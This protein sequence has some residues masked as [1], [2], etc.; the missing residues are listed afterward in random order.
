MEGSSDDPRQPL[1]S[2]P[3]KA[4]D[5]ALSERR[6]T[7]SSST[8]VDAS[9]S[10]EEEED[11]MENLSKKSQWIVLAIASGGCA[12]FNGVF[13][14]LYVISFFCT[15]SENSGML[16]W[17]TEDILEIQTRLG[18]L[19]FLFLLINGQVHAL[20]SVRTGMALR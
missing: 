18:Y 7:S 15:S 2:A 19:L 8:H 10:N 9:T 5:Q 4:A 6:A 3:A 16:F 14:K 12:A 1:L 17:G 11:K 13:A 20:M